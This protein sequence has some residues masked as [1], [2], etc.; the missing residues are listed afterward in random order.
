MIFLFCKKKKIRATAL[1]LA[2]GSP[3]FFFSCVSEKGQKGRPLISKFGSSVSSSCEQAYNL[4][5]YTCGEQCP[6]GTHPASS[7]E[8]GQAKVELESKHQEGALTEEQYRVIL[9]NLMSAQEKGEVCVL[10]AK[11]LRP[12]GAV[13]IKEDYCACKKGK[14]DLVNKCQSFCSSRPSTNNSTLYGSVRLGPEVLHHKELGSLEKWCNGEITGSQYQAPGCFLEVFD[15]QSTQ[16]LPI[17]ISSQSNHFQVDIDSL[18]YGKVYLATIVESQSGSHAQ[19]STFQ[20]YRKEPQEEKAEGPLKIMPISQ[21]SC[22]TRLASEQNGN[23]SFEKDLRLHFYFA[24]NATPPSLPSNIRT[25]ICHDINTYGEKDSPQFPRLELISQ[26]FALWDQSDI[27]FVDLDDDGRADINQEIEK[28]LKKKTGVTRN[29]NIFNLF[30]WPNMPKIEGLK[31]VENPNLGF[32]MLPWIN[33]LSGQSYCPTQDDYNGTDPIFQILKELVGLDTEGLYFAESEPAHQKEGAYTLDV[34][35][36]REKL[37]KKIWF[38]YEN[39]R[40]MI[41][42]QITSSSQTIHFYWPPD[43]HHP[44]VKKSTQRIYTVRY[45]NEIGKDGLSQGLNKTIRPPDRRF[46]CAPALD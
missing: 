4:A 29:L 9:E 25:T 12:S 16:S 20:I 45:P 11:V 33:P 41:P 46:A 44:Y 8:V 26:H 13:F 39:T 7:Q 21:Y 34:I 6:E 1:A 23:F 36:I 27:R 40:H 38:Y 22:I 10:G 43:T 14:S 19:S 37:L 3:F 24:S 18:A 2:L 15:G 30:N 17:V 28:R 42:D 32:F 31:Q 35:I 5:D